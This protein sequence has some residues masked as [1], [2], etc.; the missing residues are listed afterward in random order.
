MGNPPITKW[1][2]PNFVVVFENDKVLHA[3][4][5]PAE[6]SYTPILD[7]RGVI[8]NHGDLQRRLATGKLPRLRNAIPAPP[9]P[10]RAAQSRQRWHQLYGSARSLALAEAVESDTR[11]YLVIARDARELD[12]LRSELGFFLGGARAST[13]CPTGKCCPTTCSRR[14]R[15][16]SPSASRRWPSCRD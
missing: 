13:C 14:T 15:T 2:Y 1:F 7:S 16:S 12:Q 11:P 3:V 4:V 8:R 6:A 5:S 10:S 9:T